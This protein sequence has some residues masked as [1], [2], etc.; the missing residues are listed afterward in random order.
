MN[1]KSRSQKIDEAIEK[2]HRAQAKVFRRTRALSHVHLKPSDKTFRPVTYPLIQI[3]VS[4]LFQHDSADTA[5][6][7]SRFVLGRGLGVSRPAPRS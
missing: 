1:K 7:L 3:S 2:S 6:L 5:N 4:P